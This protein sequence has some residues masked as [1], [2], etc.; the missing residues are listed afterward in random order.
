MPNSEQLLLASSPWLML[1]VWLPL[2]MVFAYFARRPVHALLMTVMR[3]IRLTARLLTAYCSRA[4]FIVRGWCERLLLRQARDTTAFELRDAHEQLA[5]QA[6]KELDTLPVLRQ[7]LGRHVAALEEDFQRS[8][9]TPAEPPNWARVMDAVSRLGAEHTGAVGRTLED[10]RDT[11]AQQRAD[12]REQQ[13]QQHQRRYL[14]LYRMM[15]RWRR[16]QRVLEALDVRLGRLEQG[17]RMTRRRL[18]AYQRLRQTGR[19]Q[20][21]VLAAGV[22]G[23]FLVAALLLGLA[24]AGVAAYGGLAAEPMRSVIGDEVLLPGVAAWQMT[25]GL[26]IGLQLLLGILLLDSQR[27]SRVIPP[28]TGLPSGVRRSI[29]WLSFCAL[30]LIAA[31][32][33]SA[34]YWLAMQTLSVAPLAVGGIGEQILL[35]ILGETVLSGLLLL[36]PFLLAFAAVPLGML[37]TTVRPV[38][39]MIL[40][41]LLHT[42]ALL[43]RGLSVSATVAGRLLIQMYDVFIAIPLWIERLIQARFRADSDRT[44]AQTPAETRPVPALAAIEL[45]G[46]P[47]RNA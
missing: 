28:L 16:V 15:P 1:L 26:L 2:A 30:L 47:E 45:S 14:L 19:R 5:S 33:A 29:F 9:D 27:V 7:R 37:G 23:R 13:R 43:G 18:V 11:L 10:I 22:L 25:L 17:L 34:Y 41:A 42:G 38:T 4:A 12:A 21:V 24:I 3:S 39:A 44:G 20:L 6:R 36:F 35:G 32:V 31:G 46:R 8:A 40:W